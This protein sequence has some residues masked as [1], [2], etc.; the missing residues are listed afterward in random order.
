[1][2]VLA[3]ALANVSVTDPGA[4]A[5]HTDVD[6]ALYCPAVHAVQFTALEPL[7]VVVTEPD[8][9]NAHG[10]VTTA[11]YCPAAH[12]TQLTAPVPVSV[13]VTEPAW[14]IQQLDCSA[15]P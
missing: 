1:V 4:H 9:H 3:P 10:D 8:A 13:S 2:H 6:T 14:H 11:L 12:A 15:L 5:V 7:K